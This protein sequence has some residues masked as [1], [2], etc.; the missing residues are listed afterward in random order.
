MEKIPV[1]PIKPTISLDALNAIDVR[2]GTI[3]LVE[4]VK[5]SDKLIQLTVNFG[6][7][8]RTILARIMLHGRTAPLD[9][10]TP[11]TYRGLRAGRP[12]GWGSEA[13]SRLAPGLKRPAT[14]S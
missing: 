2:I 11:H 10:T 6:N 4:D 8:K 1:A 3:E 9:G 14:Q 13:S 5:G 7:H 12:L